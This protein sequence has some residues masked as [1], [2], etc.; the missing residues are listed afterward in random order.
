MRKQIVGLLAVS[1]ALISTPVCAVEREEL[2][3]EA[4]HVLEGMEEKTLK[5]APAA[6]MPSGAAMR[7]PADPAWKSI[8][9]KQ[10]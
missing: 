8:P 2:F 9:T 5:P 4:M 10:L 6:Q 3:S 1:L 7:W